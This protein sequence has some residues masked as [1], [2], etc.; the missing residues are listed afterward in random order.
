[1]SLD[2]DRSVWDGSSDESIGSPT[3]QWLSL[4]TADSRRQGSVLDLAYLGDC[5]ANA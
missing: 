4:W 5:E 2:K 3:F 1:M